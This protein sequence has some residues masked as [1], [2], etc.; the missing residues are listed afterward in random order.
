MVVVDTRVPSVE[1]VMIRERKTSD[2]TY[3]VNIIKNIERIPSYCRFATDIGGLFECDLVSRF[4]RSKSRVVPDDISVC[5]WFGWCGDKRRAKKDT[6][7]IERWPYADISYS[8]YHL[9]LITP[10]YMRFPG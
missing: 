4:T 6:I 5:R 9:I 7:Y 8:I 3:M 2:D 1:H 10:F